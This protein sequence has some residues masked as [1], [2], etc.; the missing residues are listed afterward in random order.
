[1]KA[2]VYGTVFQILQGKIPSF[3]L[4]WLLPYVAAFLG[5]MSSLLFNEVP[6]ASSDLLPPSKMGSCGSSAYPEN[7]IE[8]AHLKV[9]TLITPHKYLL[10]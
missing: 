7:S 4:L 1:M 8:S 3:P 5:L 2:S 10:Q 9:L 6:L